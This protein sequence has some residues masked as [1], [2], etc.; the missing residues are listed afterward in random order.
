M[1]KKPAAKFGSGHRHFDVPNA[2]YL[3]EALKG[4]NNTRVAFAETRYLLE[5]NPNTLFAE[6]KQDT[7]GS[8][9]MRVDDAAF[10][11]AA[12]STGTSRGRNGSSSTKA[13]AAGGGG[14]GEGFYDDEEEDQNKSLAKRLQ[15]AIAID[16]LE[17][18]R[19]LIKAQLRASELAISKNPFEREKALTVIDPGPLAQAERMLHEQDQHGVKQFVKYFPSLRSKPRFTTRIVQVSK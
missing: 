8:Y 18:R 17:E 1:K 14:G 5:R 13:A 19:R 15:A 3:N 16:R 10:A 6:T 12:T 9:L 7:K 4:E 11:A 2:G